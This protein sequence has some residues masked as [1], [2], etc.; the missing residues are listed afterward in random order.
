[1]IA[2][3]KWQTVGGAK[4]KFVVKCLFS[5]EGWKSKGVAARLRSRREDN[6]ALD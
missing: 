6:L 4:T 5:K 2:V 1:M 3:I